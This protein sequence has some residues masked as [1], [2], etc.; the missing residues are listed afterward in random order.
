MG[1]GGFSSTLCSPIALPDLE[2]GLSYLS[3][4]NQRST[5][6]MGARARHP[7]GFFNHPK[8][9]T[10]SGAGCHPSRPLRPP[11]KSQGTLFN[12]CLFKSPNL[13][14]PPLFHLSSTQG[15]RDK[16]CLS[17]KTCNSPM[18]AS[19]NCCTPSRDHGQSDYVTPCR[20][21]AS[22][23]GLKLCN[24]GTVGGGGTQDLSTLFLELA[25]VYN[26]PK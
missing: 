14:H 2:T 17:L 3:I 7:S 26:H 16:I 24:N 1:W 23:V 8:R 12:W 5:P 19:R 21:P 15:L 22:A 13:S 10:P 20:F 18:S 11:R 4:E 9:P 6:P 25:V